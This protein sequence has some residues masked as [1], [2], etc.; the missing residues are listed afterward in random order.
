[1]ADQKVTVTEAGVE[2][3]GRILN[4]HGPQSFQNGRDRH[5]LIAL[6]K[7][8]CP[9]HLLQPRDVYTCSSGLQLNKI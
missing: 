7:S 4:S 8:G 1:M 3:F 6:S 9:V 2:I 5:I